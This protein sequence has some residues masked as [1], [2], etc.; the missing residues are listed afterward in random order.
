MTLEEAVALLEKG[1][2][3][4]EGLDAVGKEWSESATGEPFVVKTSAGKYK[5]KEAA[6]VSWFVAARG[7]AAHKAGAIYWRIRP[8]VESGLTGWH[9]YARLLV[10]D[11][12]RLSTAAEAA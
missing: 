12:P 3:V 2:E 9:V 10:S 1:R 5:T 11:K 6:I 8:E 4:Y 7:Y